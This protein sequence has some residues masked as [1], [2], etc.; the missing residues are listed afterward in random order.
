QVARLSPVWE[1]R[2]LAPWRAYRGQARSTPPGWQMEAAGVSHTRYRHRTF[3]V[4]SDVRALRHRGH[5]RG[6]WTAACRNH[7][8]NRLDGMARPAE[9]IQLN[10]GCRCPF[11]DDQRQST[12]I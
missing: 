12:R 9:Q 3:F 1:P 6:G 2:N 11:A 4:G 5:A 8:G 10:R 7:M